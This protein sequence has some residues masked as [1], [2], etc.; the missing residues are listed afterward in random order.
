MPR[1]ISSRVGCGFCASSSRDCITMPGVQKPHCTA[2]ASTK[3]FSMRWP[4]GS[5]ARPSMVVMLR[6]S[7][8]T[9]NSRQEFID[10]PSTMMVHAPHS[11]SPQPYLVPVRPTTLRIMSSVL[12]STGTRTRVGTPLSVKLISCCSDIFEHP[13]GHVVNQLLAVP[14]GGPHVGDGGDLVARRGGRGGDGVGSEGAALER[15]FRR[16]AA[17]R[18]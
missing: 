13:P 5:S 8:S 7:Q 3:A 6:P 10:E 4:M 1:W 18:R 17:H 2:P 9:A 16:R 12:M 15:L 14:G 11:P